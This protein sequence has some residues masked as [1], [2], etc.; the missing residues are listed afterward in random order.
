MGGWAGG[1]EEEWRQLLKEIRLANLSSIHNLV[2]SNSDIS[3]GLD[4]TSLSL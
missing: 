3:A 1:G 2:F 4:T